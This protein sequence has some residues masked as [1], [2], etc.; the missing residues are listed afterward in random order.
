MKRMMLNETQLRLL[1]R[2]MLNEYGPEVS[3]EDLKKYEFLLGEN[4][5][6]QVIAALSILSML[7]MKSRQDFGSAYDKLTD[8]ARAL[9]IV[10]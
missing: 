3:N 5:K 6:G 4:E 2:G 8:L 10:P 9:K 1:V 7:S